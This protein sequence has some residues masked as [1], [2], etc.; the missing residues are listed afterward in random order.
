MVNVVL[1]EK[2]GK[3]GILTMNRPAKLNTLNDD[4]LIS[5][6][7]GIMRFNE[8]EDVNVIVLK[9]AGRAFCAG[10]DLS[11]REKPFI[12]V[13]DWREHAQ[14][15]NRTFFAIW[16]SKKPVIASVQGYSMGGG[17]DLA[18]VCDFTVASEEAVFGEPEIQFSSSSS[19][20]LMPWAVGMKKAKYAL[21]TGDRINAKEAERIGIAT[22]VV[23]ADKLDGEVM[24]LADRLMK[25]PVPAMR[26]NK[27]AIN[28][29]Y[30]IAGLRNA[31]IAGETI[32]GIVHMSKT[33]ENEE[34][35][36]VAAKEGL[37]AAFKWRDAKFAD[38]N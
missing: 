11:P 36:A 16:D 31:L 32:F 22:Y 23:P 9:A 35:F 2:Q 14:L 7:D 4:M 15:G 10:F 1:C 19:F 5:L 28:R 27:E 30:E 6:Y 34:F 26:L 20:F 33:P 29:S 21:L 37:S 25:I 13:Q 12:T 24:A 3:V 18:M 17:C 38:E 8:D